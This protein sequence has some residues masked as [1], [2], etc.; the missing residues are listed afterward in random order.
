MIAYI[1]ELYVNRKAPECGR[2]LIQLQTTATT[3][4]GAIEKAKTIA[5]K[6]GYKKIKS[7]RV[8]QKKYMYWDSGK[9]IWENKYTLFGEVENYGI[10]G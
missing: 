10:E 2:K 4:E 5:K 3:F 7:F 9:K 1:V 8:N 6:Q